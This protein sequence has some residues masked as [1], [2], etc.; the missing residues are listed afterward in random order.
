MIGSWRDLLRRAWR[1]PSGRWGAFALLVLILVAAFA[2]FA[3]PD[4]A[5]IP[6]AVAG[7]TPPSASHPMGT[8]LLGREHAV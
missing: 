2:P 7:A 1:H 6:D 8:D 5:A 3:L 4:P